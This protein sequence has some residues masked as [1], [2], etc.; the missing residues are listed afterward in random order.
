MNDIARW[1]VLW[2]CL[3][4]GIA[5]G[6]SEEEPK[7]EP[8]PA[9]TKS[10]P[11]KSEPPKEEPAETPEAPA[12]E[13]AFRPMNTEPEPPRT[14][15]FLALF[16]QW[17][18]LL[19]D[20]R[21]LRVQYRTSQDEGEKEEI[22]EQ[23]YDL[24]AR[25][26]EMEPQVASAARD[27]YALR[28]DQ[29][30]DAE[31]FLASRAQSEFRDDQYERSGPL[32]ILLAEKGYQNATIYRIAGISSLETMNFDAAEK[33][34][35]LALQNGAIAPE[36]LQRNI[37]RSETAINTPEEL[38]QAIQARREKWQREKK[39]REQDKNLP[40]V[41]LTTTEGEVVLELFEDHAPNAVANFITLVEKGF[42][43][44]VIFHRVLPGFMAQG[45]D[46]EGTGAG[47]PGYNIISE[48]DR[49]DH[50]K[51]FRGSLSMANTGEPNSGGSQ[52][53]ITYRATPHLD[54]RHTVFGRVI[55]GMEV[56]ADFQEVDPNNPDPRFE[57]T[58]I[59]EAEVLRKRDH[60]YT[61][62]KVGDPAPEEE[63]PTKEDKP[64]KKDESKPE[65]SK[66]DE[67]KPDD[68]A[69][70]KSKSDESK[71]KAE[72]AEEKK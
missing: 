1:L 11:A 9:E 31:R 65:K 6:Q 70:E 66:Q 57:P 25:G 68:P 41:K 50:R 48:F 17:R 45:G 53:F 49:E 23:Y 27:I 3:L 8:P 10:D 42:Y 20:L 67:S 55:D 72:K 22:K 58:K 63:K 26:E 62:R 51:H 28:P 61:V 13:E 60:E 35:T 59:V 39:L 30:K 12:E 14:D 15:E 32:A 56:V 24:I 29:Y 40:R 21:A 64:T 43:N 19:G 46:P 36:E 18:N 52:F 47:G 54:G 2:T 16:D 5:W 33:Y 38:K 37:F 7:P 69:K 34:L 4:G 71:P 44:G